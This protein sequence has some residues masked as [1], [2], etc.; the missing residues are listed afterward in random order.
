MLTPW[1]C[2]TESVAKQWVLSKCRKKY[3]QTRWDSG[4]IVKG[5]GHFSGCGCNNFVY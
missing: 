5:H 2:N 4:P 1:P 3:D